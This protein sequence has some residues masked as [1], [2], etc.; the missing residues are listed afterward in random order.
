MGRARRLRGSLGGLPTAVAAAAAAAAFWQL[1]AAA[2]CARRMLTLCLGSKT[3]WQRVRQVM[4]PRSASP[5]HVI[6]AQHVTSV[7]LRRPAGLP[8][9]TTPRPAGRKQAA[10]EAPDVLQAVTAQ[11]AEAL[12]NAAAAVLAPAAAKVCVV[13]G[14]LWVGGL[15]EGGW[16]CGGLF[17][18]GCCLV[19]SDLFDW[20]PP[21][22]H[23]SPHMHSRMP[24]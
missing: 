5:Q 13:Q 2:A 6:S 7:I 9:P 8:R 12:S 24:H 23:I 10:D 17:Q 1:G 18:P 20:L 4:W 15:W 14:G 11:L 21:P 16:A 19:A 22:N 3:S